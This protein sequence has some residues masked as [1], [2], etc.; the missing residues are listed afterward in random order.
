MV[1]PPRQDSEATGSPA[2]PPL[3]A[4]IEGELGRMRRA[5]VAGP[6]GERADSWARIARS[7]LGSLPGGAESR[8]PW[9]RRNRKGMVL[10]QGASRQP[11]PQPAAQQPPA[12]ADTCPLELPCQRAAAPQLAHLAR[13]EALLLVP[14]ELLPHLPAH[15]AGTAGALPVAPAP[16]ASATVE[17]ACGGLL[18]GRSLGCGSSGPAAGLAARSAALNLA[19]CGCASSAARCSATTSSR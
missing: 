15:H 19:G 9:L 3:A 7:A 11:A 13:C 5:L 18:A 2:G 16:A 17:P 4:Q 8:R 10:R 12:A 14:A 1:T 6:R